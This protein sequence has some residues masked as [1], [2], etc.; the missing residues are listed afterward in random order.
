[1]PASTVVHDTTTTAPVTK[2][3]TTSGIEHLPIAVSAQLSSQGQDP[4]ILLPSSCGQQNGLLTAL[5]TFSGG[6]VPETDVR[7]GDV[8]ELYADTA[9]GSNGEQSIQVAALGA[10]HPF[11]MEGNGPWKVTVPI[12][13][14]L[15]SPARCL[16]AVQSTHAFMAANNAGS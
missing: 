15:G 13:A 6:S 11:T 2:T 1:L 5:G 3:L 9:P 4:S 16:I 8:V 14:Q 10:E 12:D 7:Y